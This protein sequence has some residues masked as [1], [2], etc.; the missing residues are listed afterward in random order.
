VG[1]GEYKAVYF[2]AGDEDLPNLKQFQ[3]TEVTRLV[4]LG[5]D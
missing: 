2:L 1:V 5:D 4:F 3:P